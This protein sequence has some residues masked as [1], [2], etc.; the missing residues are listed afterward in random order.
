MDAR[1]AWSMRR[2][3]ASTLSSVSPRGLVLVQLVLVCYCSFLPIDDDRGKHFYIYHSD[4]PSRW[5]TCAIHVS[6]PLISCYLEGYHWKDDHWPYTLPIT[7]QSAMH[8]DIP[9]D[10]REMSDMVSPYPVRLNVDVVHLLR[11]I[12]PCLATFSM[13][14]FPLKSLRGIPHFSAFALKSPATTTRP[15][16]FWMTS[17]IAWRFTWKV[18]PHTYLSPDS[19]AL[20]GILV[21]FTTQKASVPEVSLHQ[22]GLSASWHCSLM[23]TI[24]DFFRYELPQ[25]IFCCPAPV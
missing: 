3:V 20:L 12:N 24:S 17:L 23:M 11:T 21:E 10:A 19:F 2:I 7:F 15:S 6:I 4:V 9:S 18:K 16:I 14:R 25:T 8:F 13:M 1:H 5:L 22:V